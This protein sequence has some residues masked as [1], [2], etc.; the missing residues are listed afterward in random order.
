MGNSVKHTLLL[1]FVTLLAWV[2]IGQGHSRVLPATHAVAGPTENAP[3]SY[4]QSE[5]I[6]FEFLLKTG[7][8]IGG[9]VTNAPAPGSKHNPTDLSGLA[10][11]LEQRLQR[12]VAGSVARARN[13]S[14]S[15][16]SCDI[17]FPFHNF[18]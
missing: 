5:Q 2:G 17:I 7:E 15:L 3:S 4:F 11:P 8:T 13:I 6:R 10:L 14:L 9:T 12:L 18:W 1:L 16:G